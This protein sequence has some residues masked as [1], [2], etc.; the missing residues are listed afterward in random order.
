MPRNNR[1]LVLLFMLCVAAAIAAGAVTLLPERWV[2]WIPAL[3]GAGWTIGMVVLARRIGVE[4]G[5]G[6]PRDLPA[7]VIA[8]GLLTVL[9]VSWAA[10]D[11]VGWPELL[12]LTAALVA[13]SFWARAMARER[14]RRR[15]SPPAPAGPVLRLRERPPGRR[16]PR[17]DR[18]T[19]EPREPGEPRWN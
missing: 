12:L 3:V 10:R 5:S 19:G 2:R 18:P 7:G 4:T 17:Q 13:F 1:Y 16:V 15:H 6:R 8:C 11:S 9:A 14:K